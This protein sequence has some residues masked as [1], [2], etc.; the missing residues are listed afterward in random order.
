MEQLIYLGGVTLLGGFIQGFS[1]FGFVLI[2][3]PLLAIFLDVKIAIPLTSLMGVVLTGFLLLTLWKDFEWRRVWPLLIGALPGVPIGIFIL[4]A[5]NSRWLLI[6][7]GMILVCYSLYG[8]LFKTINKELDR[9]WAYFSGFLSGCC[10]GAVSASGPPVIVYVSLQPWRK[11]LIQATLQ[12]FF[13]ISG[14]MVV[15]GQ[16]AAVLITLPVLKL[17]LYSIAPLVLGTYVGHFFFGR[18]G[19]K[20]HRQVILGLL[21][22]LGSFTLLRA[23]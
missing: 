14:L 12:G 9:R 18:I 11:E 1:G 6:V 16:A 15:G 19:E 21:F 8:L 22:C 13:F 23:L 4:K 3:L 10:G 17:F 20:T 2:S 7:M 5:L